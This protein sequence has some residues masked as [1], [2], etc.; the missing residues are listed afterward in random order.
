[1]A[2]PLDTNVVLRYLVEDPETTEPRFRG[3]VA[4]FEKI[5][6]GERTA[7]LTPLVLFQCY[8]V[9]TSYYEVPRAEAAAK[10][11]EVLSYK[12]LRVPE[13]PVLRACLDTLSE[14][15]VD[16]VDAYLAALCIQKR[17][18]GVYSYDEGLTRLG[19]DLLPVE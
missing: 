15:S 19:V 11:R 7:L 10:L 16:L 3:A 4:F 8:F 14:R 1:M 6:R 2:D 18:A 12:G 17:L 5:E 13:K 9:L